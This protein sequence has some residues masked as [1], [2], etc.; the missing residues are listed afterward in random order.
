MADTAK[1]EAK[2]SARIGLIEHFFRRFFDTLAVALV[3]LISAALARFYGVL[4]E[5]FE[6]FGVK[7]EFVIGELEDTTIQFTRLAEE[8]DQRIEKTE[9]DLQLLAARIA[10]NGDLRVSELATSQSPSQTSA[11]LREL[12]RNVERDKVLTAKELA[13]DPNLVTKLGYVWLGTWDDVTGAWLDASVDRVDG[14]KLTGDP[15]RMSRDTDLL[16]VTDLNLRAGAP[17]RSERYFRDQP[18]LGIVPKGETLTLKGETLQYPSDTGLQIWGRVEADV[19]PV[20][21]N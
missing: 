4:P 10:E 19:Y 6:A 21:A 18:K 5:K 8:F 14:T 17:D 16:V 20:T 2:P 13:A 15:A 11:V 9:A 7:G 3:L 12:V 1:P